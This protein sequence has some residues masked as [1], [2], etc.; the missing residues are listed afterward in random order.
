MPTGSLPRVDRGENEPGIEDADAVGPR[1]LRALIFTL[2]PSAMLYGTGLVLLPK[3]PIEREA[4]LAALRW[5][6]ACNLLGT[7]IIVSLAALAGWRRRLDWTLSA[8]AATSAASL[9]LLGPLWAGSANAR[10]FGMGVAYALVGAAK[11]A[12]LIRLAVSNAAAPGPWARRIAVYAISALTYVRVTGWAVQVSW[13][14]GDGP[15]YLLLA[16]SLATDHDFDL[17][18]NYA[19]KDYLQFFPAHLEGSLEDYPLNSRAWNTPQAVAQ[20][21]HSV[22]VP[23]GAELLWHDVGTSVVLL[24]GY[25]VRGRR[26]ALIMLDLVAAALALSIFEL[27]A[28]LRAGTGAALLAWATFAFS[29]PLLVFAGELSPEIIGGAI[30]AG[31]ATFFVK[32]MRAPALG[33]ELATGACLALLPWVCIRYWVTA[34]ALGAVAA[35]HVLTRAPAARASSRLAGFIALALP[36]A[37]STALFCWVD[38]RLFGSWRPNAGYLQI[39]VDQPQFEL[40]PDRG[41]LG[42]L[43]DRAYGLLPFAPAYVATAAG[44]ILAWRRDRWQAAVLCVPSLAYCGVMSFSRYW[45]GGWTPPSRYLVAGIA[46]VPPLGALILG[47]KRERRM[48]LALAAWGWTIAAAFVAVPLLRYPSIRDTTRSGLHDF[49]DVTRIFPSI[50]TYREIDLFAAAAWLSISGYLAWRF[51]RTTR[52][53]PPIGAGD[54]A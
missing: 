50:V 3:L 25:L 54:D 39:V 33:Y 28:M 5:A 21:H 6:A 13:P 51:L 30:I 31:A 32:G 48:A 53:A 10:V 20:Q 46:L 19:Q 41:I 16:H 45:Y 11:T 4:L 26:G 15:A 44:A 29:P 35:A 9:L 2:L 24:P 7:G 38:H 1:L 27:A 40:R 47:S 23:S 34:G 17:R 43:F 22:T 52:D 36:T 18:N 49:L 14:D 12:I 37:V 8:D 42:L